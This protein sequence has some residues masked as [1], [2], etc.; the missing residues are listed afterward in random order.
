MTDALSRKQLSCI[1]VFNFT[2]TT[3][4]IAL[5]IVVDVNENNCEWDLGLYYLRVEQSILEI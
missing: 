4:E 1:S 3:F 5:T 2:K